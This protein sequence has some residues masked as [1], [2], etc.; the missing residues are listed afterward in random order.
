MSIRDVIGKIW[1]VTVHGR[2]SWSQYWSHENV[3]SN[4]PLPVHCEKFRFVRELVK[5]RPDRRKTSHRGIGEKRVLCVFLL[6]TSLSLVQNVHTYPVRQHRVSSSDG[7]AG[8]ICYAV[9]A[10]RLLRKGSISI[11][12]PVEGDEGRELHPTVAQLLV[13][14]TVCVGR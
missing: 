11:V 7:N 2:S 13:G 5:Q 10:V 8:C 3:T 6:S 14:V 1:T 4:E 12:V 9:P